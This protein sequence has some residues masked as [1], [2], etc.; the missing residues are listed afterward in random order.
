MKANRR[1]FLKKAVISSAALSAGIGFHGIN[2]A[3]RVR[4]I[5]KGV[6]KGNFQQDFPGWDISF[7]EGTSVLTLRNGPVLLK[8]KLTFITGSGAGNIVKSRFGT[9][10]RYSLADDKGASLGYFVFLKTPEH[11]RLNF[12]RPASLP[13]KGS[14]SFD[15][16]INFTGDS[17]PCRTKP[18]QGERVLSLRNGATESLWYD[19]IVDP[20]IDT[21]IRF[22]ASDLV[23]K[24]NQAGSFPVS[25]SGNTDE[26]TEEIFSIDIE[27]DYYKNRWVPFFHA[28]DRKR[29]PRNPTGW[30]SWNTYFD[31]ATAD[32]NL[33]EARIGQKYF[34]PYG[35]E[36]W[37][38]ESWQ[39][40]SDILPVRNFY[41]MNLE[42]SE[43]KFPK[44]MKK[45]ADDIRKLG[46]RPGIWM[47]PFGTGNK[48]FYESNKS[49]FLHDKDGKPVTC[50]NGNYTMDPTVPEALENLARIHRIASHEWGYEYFKVDGMNTQPVWERPEVRARFHDPSVTNPFEVCMKIIRDA[51]GEDRFLLACGGKPSGPE[52]AYCDAFRIANDIVTQFQPAKWSGIVRTSRSF[53]NN[54]YVSNIAMITDPDTLLVRELPVEEARVYATMVALPGQHTF[55]GDKLAKCSP[56]QIKMLQQTLPVVP[57][58]P[59]SLY[60]YFSDMPVWNVSVS[61]KILD[62]YNVIG[63]F[64][65]SDNP[66]TISFTTEELGIDSQPGTVSLG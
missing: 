39:G 10:V 28:L 47:A 65:W 42:T 22:T 18:M 62:N 44:G 53:I 8:G 13:E 35:C 3:A 5:G 29:V 26:F 46:F 30:M 61:N 17:F 54:A 1:N 19:S 15:G 48:E 51:I 57:S 31:T 23:I 50:W 58:R 6:G 27:K 60:P 12:Y 64:N 24:N 66:Q 36:F 49:W 41:N 20:E 14:L 21:V 40:N 32:D 25:M 16:K 55:F 4:E 63:L 45:L 38:I 33:N 34:Q 2:A 9:P 59:V 52:A 7:D 56:E 37:S 43:K 11:I